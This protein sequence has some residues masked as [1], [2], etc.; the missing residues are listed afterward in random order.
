[1]WNLPG[2][3]LQT[4]GGADYDDA[5]G[6]WA[7][8]VW[9]VGLQG[10]GH[11]TALHVAAHSTVVY[12]RQ[13][14]IPT[15]RGR[16]ERSTHAYPISWPFETGKRFRRLRQGSFSHAV[17]PEVR[18]GAVIDGSAPG[19]KRAGTF[20]PCRI[21]ESWAGRRDGCGRASSERLVMNWPY[22]PGPLL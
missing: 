9:R 3:Q 17:I 11:W 1:M 5:E 20:R 8:L 15:H 22:R 10:D 21:C 16:H 18:A 13:V 7:F 12:N 4:L 14:K 6:R 2:W 19:G